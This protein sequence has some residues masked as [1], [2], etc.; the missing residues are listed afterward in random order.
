MSAVRR[1]G[2]V[3]AWVVALCMVAGACATS[4]E[5]REIDRG[6]DQV[7]GDPPTEESEDYEFAP[8]PRHPGHHGDVSMD[9]PAPATPAG[10][11]AVARQDL[12]RLLQYG[13]SVIFQHVD[14]D[15]YREGERF[16]GFRII[17]L[18][19]RAQE[20]LSPRLR[21]GDVVTHV[22][23][24]KVERPEDYTEVWESLEDAEEIR[25]DFLRDGEAEQV[26]WRVQ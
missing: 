15:P 21:V 14:T 23:L 20:I 19:D 11:D 8:P 12:N 22:N 24:V 6:P 5:K 4:P 16:V 17:D 3:A 9:S 10:R 7:V 2:V 1:R 26:I 18:S 13:P 25:V